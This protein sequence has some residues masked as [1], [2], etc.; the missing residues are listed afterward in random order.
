MSA[1]YSFLPWVRQGAVTTVGTEDPLDSSL[2]PDPDLPLRLRLNT[3]DEI[4][5]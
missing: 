5:V 2:R 4:D 1:V 3:A